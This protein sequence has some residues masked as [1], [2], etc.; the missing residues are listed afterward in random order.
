MR[1]PI[2][3]SAVTAAVPDPA[4][5]LRVV[6]PN[7]AFVPNWKTNVVAAPF[8]STV[9]VSVTAF[10]VVVV[11]E[12]V[13]AVGVVAAETAWVVRALPFV[14]PEV[15]PVLVVGVPVPLVALSVALGVAFA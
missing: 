5:M 13:V 10:G 12:P 11:G 7:A 1:P 3:A 14:A 6:E 9:P 15:D 8:R 2:V 4:L